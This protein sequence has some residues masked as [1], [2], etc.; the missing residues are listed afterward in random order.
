MI[1]KIAEAMDYLEAYGIDPV[2]GMILLANT[3]ANG[4]VVDEKVASVAD[5]E[6][7][8]AQS[9][10]LVEVAQY[11][12]G[13]ND[14]IV[15]VAMELDELQKEAFLGTALKL[16]FNALKGVGSQVGRIFTNTGIGQKVVNSN[17]FNTMKQGFSSLKNTVSNSNIYKGAITDYKNLSNK[18]NAITPEQAKAWGSNI[19][20]RT[21]NFV[22]SN[23]NK[24]MATL[25][26][27][28]L[29]QNNKNLMGGL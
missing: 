1:E 6:L 11:L 13:V 23:Y 20:N 14:E 3:D 24:T 19:V 25:G 17:T 29:N 7:D 21:S 10:A 27:T 18:I 16:G 22:K 26:A 12:G 8:G 28:D 9:A 15:K 2:G 5:Y 4:N